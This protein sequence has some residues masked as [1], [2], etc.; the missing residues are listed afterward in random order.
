[1][2]PVFNYVLKNA[3]EADLGVTFVHLSVSKTVETQAKSHRSCIQ[4][5]LTFCVS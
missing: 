2:L 4:S 3:S 5:L 1:M